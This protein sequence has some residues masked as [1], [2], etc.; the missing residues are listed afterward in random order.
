MGG[1]DEATR[2]VMSARNALAWG[3]GVAELFGVG[4]S[5]AGLVY[6]ANTKSP[7]RCHAKS[8]RQARDEA[9]TERRCYWGLSRAYSSIKYRSVMPAM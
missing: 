8:F 4:V 6:P 5:T 3:S 7:P 1:R 2:P 9:A